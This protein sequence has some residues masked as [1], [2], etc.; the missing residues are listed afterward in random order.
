VLEHAAKRSRSEAEVRQA[1]DQAL[2]SAS[3]LKRLTTDLLTLTKSRS[4]PAQLHLDLLDLAN[5]VIDRLMPLACERRLDLDIDGEATPFQGDPVLISRMIE[6]LVANAIKFTDEGGIRVRVHPV[7][8]HAELSV[9][10]DGIGFPAGSCV[11]FSNRSVGGTRSAGKGSGWAWPWSGASP[12]HT[13]S[14]WRWK[15]ESVTVHA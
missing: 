4:A 3:H 7:N 15:A 13:E 11:S 2:R 10:D 1:L 8:E 6:N 5:E 9:T 12:R 14:S